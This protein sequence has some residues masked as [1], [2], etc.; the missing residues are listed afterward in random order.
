[1]PPFMCQVLRPTV[2]PVHES[3]DIK[4][5]KYQNWLSCSTRSPSAFNDLVLFQT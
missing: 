5:P 1:M 2:G 4:L 3:S